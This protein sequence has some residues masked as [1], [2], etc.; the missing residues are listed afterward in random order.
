MRPSRLGVLWAIALATVLV[1]ISGGSVSAGYIRPGYTDLISK[2]HASKGSGLVPTASGQEPTTS[3]SGD[4]RF[5]AFASDHSDLVPGDVNG[6]S[7]VFLY[8]RK[9][10]R[11][12]LISKSSSGVLGSGVCLLS[13][14][15][16][17]TE[18]GSMW[19]AIS[20]DGSSVAFQSCATDLVPGDTNQVRDVFVYDRKRGSVE[21]VSVASD[22]TQSLHGVSAGNLSIS[23]EGRYVAWTSTAPDLVEGDTNNSSDVFVHDRRTG[24]TERVS[25]SSTGEQA[26]GGVSVCPGLG[27]G[28]RFVAFS[29][30][31]RN[32][33]PGDVNNA[34]DVFLRDRKLQT[35]EL[36]SVAS[37]ETPGSFSLGG[38]DLCSPGRAL[39]SNARFVAFRSSAPN[40]VPGDQ[41]GHPSNIEQV[42]VFVRD[43][44]LG[45]TDRISVDSSGGESDFASYWPS[46]TADGRYVAF[47]STSNDLAH[48]RDTG[49]QPNLTGDADVFL[50]DRLYGSTEMINVAPDG[51]EGADSS[52]VAEGWSPDVSRD[53]RYVAFSDLSENLVPHDEN[54]W[55]DSFVRD[56]G[57]DLGVGKVLKGGFDGGVSRSRASRRSQ[58]YLS[59]ALD[60]S[61][62]IVGATVARRRSGDIFVRV[63][64]EELAE[65]ARLKTEL[66]GYVYGVRLDLGASAYEVRIQS[67]LGS[68]GRP[69][70][71]IGLFRCTGGNCR[72]LRSLEGGYGSTGEEV[73]AVVPAGVIETYRDRVT[74]FTGVGV[75]EAGN[76]LRLDSLPLAAYEV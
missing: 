70:V 2:A 40:L 68:A 71:K 58:G 29:S 61:G 64:V 3:I 22:G 18:T 6:A 50:H 76:I 41:G 14:D 31:A 38:S 12:T 23:H 20:E 27:A 17:F 46:I 52:G 8:D 7:D 21:R 24:E 67:I 69:L 30:W 11:T 73:V 26:T 32:L 60:L 37:D 28:G 44:K 54:E 75:F 56:R 53:G 4:G 16:T 33:V 34:G 48:G 25:L 59:D 9:T 13:Q 55:W 47:V 62:Q 45:R 5:V 36:I 72:F 43:R 42:D 35:T 74:A 19:P 66:T 57:P 15:G 63:A 10:E 39:S 1:A 49:S 51:S 65:P